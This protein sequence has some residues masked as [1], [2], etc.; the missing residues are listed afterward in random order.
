MDL[1][2]IGWDDGF[3][4]SL[5]ELDRTGLLEPARVCA[6]YGAA[7]EL[8]A[9]RGVLRADLS[10]RLAYQAA[11]PEDLPAVGDW[12]AIAARP[13]EHA[14]T[15][16]H[17]LARRT[18]LLRKTAGETSD[19]QVLAANLDAALLVTSANRDW[20]PRRMERAIALV[21]ES[22]A[23]A[24]VVL[25]KSDLCEDVPAL[26]AGV[27]EVAGDAPVVALS[28][29]TGAGMDAL[30]PHLAPGRTFVLLGS[31]GVGKSTLA[32]RL[33][34]RDVLATREIREADDRGRHATSHRELFVLPGGA[35]LMDTPGLREIALFDAAAD[36]S[37][38]F[39]ELAALGA[40]CRF[41]DCRH[42]GEPGCAVERAIAEGTL[43]RERLVSFQK[44]EREA[45]AH[46]ARRDAHARH[47]QRKEH[48]RFS[49]AVRRRQ[50]EK[51]GP[52][53]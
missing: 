4:A 38:A 50:R 45:A 13:E 43:D 34:G 25:S 39:P 22:G 14:A 3:G 2:S 8:L 9:A 19:A 10:G 24:I 42:V 15:I 21:A 1:A 37:A 41:A 35:L 17:V 12:V 5:A 11:G 31:S 20:N 49:K 36:P 18:A 32:N 44:L 29:A 30:A 28:S 7:R 51:R 6:D 40:A 48:R 53:D 26:V 47:A 46:Q 27:R 23:R 52:R 33:L 16:H